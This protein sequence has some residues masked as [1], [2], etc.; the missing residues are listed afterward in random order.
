MIKHDVAISQKMKALKFNS[1]K[2][3][4]SIDKAKKCNPLFFRNGGSK[5]YQCDYTG[6]S[7]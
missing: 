1:L 7:L 6:V 4:F 2:V 3:I 5:S